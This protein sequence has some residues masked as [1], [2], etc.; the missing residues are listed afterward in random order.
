M[1]I[2]ELIT[3]ERAP[4]LEKAKR[5]L[6]VQAHPDDF[7]F[8][9]GGTIAKLAKAGCEITYLTVTDGSRSTTN[10]NLSPE[11][12]TE[13]RMEEEERAAKILG[14]KHLMWLGYTDSEF[15][16]T[17]EARGKIIRA[18][19]QTKPDVLMT[20][21]PWLP[22]EA[23]PDHVNVGLV[24]CR[25]AM[26]S[27]YTNVNREHLD[28]RLQPHMVSTVCLAISAKYNTYVDIT[29]TIDLKIKALAEHKSQFQSETEM[30][31]GPFEMWEGLIKSVAEG[32]GKEKGMKYAEVFKV[33]TPLEMHGNLS[34]SK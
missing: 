2:S 24:A 23:H 10:P 4:L 20:L 14:V 26:F 16:P 6:C 30:G 11:K 28:D 18:I 3:G 25:A 7:E 31:L 15:Q 12:L 22:Y 34:L 33:L 13:I 1:Y 9:A 21:D 5:A 8:F 17:I 27:G 32:F 29:K 19:R